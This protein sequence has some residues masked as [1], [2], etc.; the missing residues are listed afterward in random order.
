MLKRGLG[1]GLESLIPETRVEGG[2][3]VLELALEAVR[4]NPFQPRREFE[5]EALAELAA[6]IRAHGVLQPVVVRTG[7]EG[8]ELVAGE[9]RWRASRLAG[10]ETVP[11]VVRE[12]P[13]ERLREIALIENL[14]REDL[15]PIEE[16]A[17]YAELLGAEGLSQEGLAERVGKSRSHVA[18]MLRLLGLPAAVQ[19]WLASGDITVGHAKVLLGAPEGDIVNLAERVRQSDLSVAETAELV[20]PARSR[21]ARGPGLKEDS[22]WS[23]LLRQRLA[24]PVRIVGGEVGRIEIRFKGPADLERLVALLMGE[25]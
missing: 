11:A 13:T 5:P 25:E 24:A 7:A 10:R 9:R 8:Y 17:A 1:R 2:E 16:A 18:N 19:G 6:S 23:G 22:R 3:R 4:P 21:P 20:R 14:Q 15:N 12:V